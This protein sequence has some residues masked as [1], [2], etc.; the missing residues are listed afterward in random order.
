M[1]TLKK[2][3]LSICEA[4]NELLFLLQENHSDSTKGMLFRLFKS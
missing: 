4:Q 1:N 3:C 2:N